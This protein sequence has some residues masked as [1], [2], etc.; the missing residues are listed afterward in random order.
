MPAGECRSCGCTDDDA[1]SP[2]D[3]WVLPDL[4]SEC[5]F[6]AE[7]DPPALVPPPPPS[8]R[9]PRVRARTVA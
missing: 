4:C 8:G 2:D 6:G 3:Y 5:A 7:E 1:C 9:F